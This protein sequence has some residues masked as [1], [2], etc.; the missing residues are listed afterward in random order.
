MPVSLNVLN[1]ESHIHA[2]LNV[3]R[4]CH[5]RTPTSSSTSTT[6]TTCPSGTTPACG[7]ML[8]PVGQ[9]LLEAAPEYDYMTQIVFRMF[10][11]KLVRLNNMVAT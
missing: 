1:A 11:N 7:S 10:E 6:T 5:L 8:G 2:L 4:Y 9:E 3:L